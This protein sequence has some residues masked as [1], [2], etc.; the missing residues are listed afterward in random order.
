[1]GKYTNSYVLRQI[2]LSLYHVAGRRTTK[3]FALKVI[4]SIIK[5]L[6]Q[7]FEFLSYI[8]INDDEEGSDND[9]IVIS[10]DIDT[11]HPDKIGRAIEAI[12]RVVYMDIIGKAGLFFI[13]ELK[14][15]AGEEL[16]TELYNF[17][18]DLATLQIEQHYLYR[19]R[20]KKKQQIGKPFSDVS[21]LGYTWKNVSSWKYD[22]NKKSCVLYNK[23]GEVLDNLHLDSIIENYVKNLSNELDDVP[24]EIENV[25]IADKEFEL[26]KILQTRD[27]DAETAM[28]MLH[29]DKSE[30][31]LIVK[32]LLENDFLQYTSHNII[33]LTEIGL[34]YLLKNDDTKSTD[35]K[36]VEE[37]VD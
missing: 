36:P 33:E 17:G 29:I 24:K 14:K 28:V 20:E 25:T 6:S 16:I 11:L 26:M 23:E 37:L 2:L 12:V 18:V 13:A 15:R 31:Y 4:G 27:M 22:T 21:L 32:K 9:S 34:N 5:T 10:A 8:E 30:F 3:G 7:K 19:S 1:M 35:N